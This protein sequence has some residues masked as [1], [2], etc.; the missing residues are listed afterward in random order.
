L[1]IVVVVIAANLTSGGMGEVA[2][3]ARAHAHWA[4]GTRRRGLDGERLGVFQS[5]D[6]APQRQRPLAVSSIFLGSQNLTS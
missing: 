2:L 4:P 3:R 5:G 6:A 1:P